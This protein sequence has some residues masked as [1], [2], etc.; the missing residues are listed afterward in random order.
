MTFINVSIVIFILFYLKLV[1]YI[2]KFKKLRISNSFKIRNILKIKKLYKVQVILSDMRKVYGSLILI[3]LV[4]F[5]INLV[6]AQSNFE[7]V[8]GGLSEKM[9]GFFNKVKLDEANST[10]ILL[11]LLLWMILYTLIKKTE[12]FGEERSDVNISVGIISLIVAMLSWIYIPNSVFL[13]LGGQY[14]ALGAT[15]LTVFPFIL[16][17]YFTVLV[18]PNGIIARSVWGIFFLYYMIFFIHTF[19]G[20]KDLT[21]SSGLAYFVAGIASLIMFFTIFWWR[22]RFWKEVIKAKKE[23]I[24]RNVEEAGVGMRG[25]RRVARELERGEI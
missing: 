21:L 23:R 25:L 13:A 11:G 9:S 22:E 5:Y 10:S 8:F 19:A 12:L 16:A 6:F 1:K 14:A 2:L 15:V 24:R 4:L 7:V 3:L 18:V 20:I 17:F